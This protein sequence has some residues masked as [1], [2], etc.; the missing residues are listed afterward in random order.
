M[1]KKRGR[2]EKKTDWL[3]TTYIQ[4][5]DS[6]G[7]KSG[8][9]ERKTDWLGD[10]Y[11]Q[12]YDSKNNKRGK[13]EGKKDWLG[14]KYTQKY[15]A[16]GEKSGRSEK[17]K[18][19][20]GDKYT[21]HYDS[22]GNETDRSEKKK[23]W[24]GSTYVQRYTD[25]GDNTSAAGH[26][27]RGSSGT[28]APTSS[29]YVSAD[30][31]SHG[32]SVAT[33]SRPLVI[34][35]IIGAIVIGGALLLGLVLSL[36]V[37]FSRQSHKAISEVTPTFGIDELNGSSFGDAYGITYAATLNGLGAVF[38]RKNQSRIQYRGIPAEGTLEW[39][40]NVRGGYHYSDY[41]VNQNLP[42]ALIFTTDSQG[43]DVTWPGSTWFFVNDDGTLSLVMATT[44]YDGPRQV[45]TAHET[46]FRFNQWHS[47]GISFGEQGQFIML[48]GIVVAAA[49][50]NKQKLGRGGNHETIADVPTVGESVSCYW[51]N[52]Q[53]DGGFE[54][55]VDRFR[56]SNKQRDWYLSQGSPK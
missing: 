8:R 21:Q 56:I 42:S 41:R 31:G 53:W 37:M 30:V 14:D 16:N 50:E 44:R 51:P 39:W 23:D 2:S 12:H 45:L 29:T 15:N 25:R 13:S 28:R 22:R 27:T 54:G 47:V 33:S 38:S 32:S 4:H 10:K 18:D 1:G 46:N 26:T 6:S 5:Y 48:D 19:W 20:L 24:L 17:K 9:S 40:I 36:G 49:T 7:N 35:I 43:G 55:I 11:T 34:G 52:N 3:G